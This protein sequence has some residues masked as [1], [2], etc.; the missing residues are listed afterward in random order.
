MK[1]VYIALLSILTIP[2]FAQDTISI[3]TN[4]GSLF[5]S[6]LIPEFDEPVSLA[7]IIA[8]SGPTDRDGNNPM[9]KNNSLKM[10]AEGLHQQGIASLRYDKRGIGQ[11][12]SAAVSEQDLRFEDFVNDARAWIHRL[13]EDQ[14]FGD[15]IVIG[16]SEG[17]LIGIIASKTPE[18]SKFISIAGVGFPADQ[19]LRKQLSAQQPVVLEKSAPILDELVAGNLV[20]SIP[21]WLNSLFRPNIQPYLISWFNYDPAKEITKL[22][23]PV[24]LLQ[25]TTDIQVTVDDAQNLALACPDAELVILE[26]MNHVLKE[27][28]A[29]RIKNIQTYSQPD[30]PLKEGLIDH[31]ANFIRK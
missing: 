16:H 11:S 3:E 5:G 31:I 29:D 17:S 27:S 19:V 15:I 8:G 20:D 4:T 23:I 22:E 25:G 2:G 13:A 1:A 6:L 10:L 7:L 28:D 21:P 14:R 9:M 12:V 26:G 30:L 18:V 24:L